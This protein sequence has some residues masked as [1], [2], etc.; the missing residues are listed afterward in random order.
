M[1][2]SLDKYRIAKKDIKLNKYPYRENEQ[3]IFTPGMSDSLNK[4]QYKRLRILDME[5]IQLAKEKNNY[6]HEML[7][8][9]SSFDECDNNSSSYLKALTGELNEVEIKLAL[10]KEE[11]GQ[12]IE[13][14]NNRGIPLDVAESGQEKVGEKTT[15]P[16]KKGWIKT[17]TIIVMY[18]V[19][20]A[21][22][23]ITQYD[24]LR[25][26]KSYEEIGT[27]VL[28][29]FILIAAFH[30]VAHLNRKKKKLIYTLYLGFNIVMITIMMLAPPALQHVYPETM[31]T[32]TASAWSLE[33]PI[34]SEILAGDTY[35]P[36][37]VK[38]YR[39]MEWA[40]AGLGIIMFLVIFFVIPN[41][42]WQQAKDMEEGYIVSSHLNT[43]ENETW[44][45]QQELKAFKNEIAVLNYE[46]KKIQSKIRE[47]DNSPADIIPFRK[48]LQDL[49]DAIMKNEREI[50]DLKIEAEELI[51]EL[52][53]E[54][55][56]YRV[57]YEDILSHDEVKNAF[58][59]PE[60][61]TRKDILNHFKTSTL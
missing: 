20:E 58:I 26:V 28:A 34:E 2:T 48:K 1:E 42:F 13:D 31:G 56:E 37:W 38:L 14:M 41:S 35:I 49:K 10:K 36:S 32:S 59:T 25:D 17:L 46:Q 44:S 4:S 51:I 24:S 19:I 60:W 40:P 11:K 53:T 50:S 61:N 8:Y 54:L 12:F 3:F 29:M 39:K 5:I 7:Q 43:P 6:L 27:R 47:I 30:I 15:K 22:L 9:Q 21:F 23:Y 16:K 57:E 55:N 18:L 33:E 52:D 45:A